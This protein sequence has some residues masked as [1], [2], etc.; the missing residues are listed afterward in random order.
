MSL[1]KKKYWPRKLVTYKHVLTNTKSQY[2][3]NIT[4]YYNCF[5]SV[6]RLLINNLSSRTPRL[7]C[8]VKHSSDLTPYRTLWFFGGGCDISIMCF[9][10]VKLKFMVISCEKMHMISILVRYGFRWHSD[11]PYRTRLRLVRY[12]LSEC[13]LNPCRTRM[14]TICISSVLMISTLCIYI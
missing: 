5:I 12:G 11:K 4:V 1:P 3:Y 2:L 8:N 9:F 7:Y 10:V 6:K 13:H 14:D